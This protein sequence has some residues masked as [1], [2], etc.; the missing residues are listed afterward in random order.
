MRV[1]VVGGGIGGLSTAIALRRTG[2]DV[3]ALERAL[4]VDVVG[5]GI[6]LF[7]NALRALARL[8]V[9]DDVAALGSRGRR[10]AIRTSDGRQLSTMSSDIVEGT[11]A[12][13]RADLQAV[14]GRAAGD[15]R[16]GAEATSVA[17]DGG[18]V[19]AL[20]A[21]GTVVEGDLLI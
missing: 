9:H 11:I 2:H 12:I 4:S 3:V 10:G 16:L 21:D 14:L 15:L 5:A 6:G 13:H 8:G 18:A 20:L 1:I 19:A 17:E 7:A